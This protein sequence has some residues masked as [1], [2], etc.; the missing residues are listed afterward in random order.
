MKLAV[1]ADDLTGANDTGVQFAKKGF[2]TVVSL[3]LRDEGEERIASGY[4]EVFVFDTDSRSAGSREAYERVA[5]VSRLLKS[6]QVD[7]IYKKM[8][9][10]M[11]G[12]IGAE[13]DAVYD[14]FRPDFVAVA[15]AFPGNGR[16]V[17]DGYMYLHGKPLHETE[18]AKDPKTPVRES[19]IP[20]LLAQ[21][22]NRPIGH[23]GTRDLAMGFSHLQNR[24]S[25]FRRDGIS[26]VLFDAESDEDLALV[27]KLFAQTDYRVV[28]AGSAG[29]AAHLSDRNRSATQSGPELSA[30]RHPVLLVVGSLSGKSRL[31]LERVLEQADTIGFCLYPERVVGERERK[32]EELDRIFRE[33]ARLLENKRENGFIRRMV[34]YTSDRP[35]DREKAKETGILFG[36]DSRTVSNMVAAALGEISARLVRHYDL[37][38]LVLTGGDTARQVCAH[39]NVRELRLLE[40][41]EPG[42]PVGALVGEDG[43]DQGYAV[44][45]AGGF[46]S[47]T[48]L[49]KAADILEGAIR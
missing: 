15:P 48:A 16:T 2:H 45:K 27:V 1:I 34:L 6:R 42:I 18:A 36:R 14:V 47:E 33:A 40:E 25:A 29:L 32:R 5:K 19:Y 24:L 8:D 30:C 43:S 44:T 21:Q 4:G 31:Q 41:V 23:I 12:N 46:G 7:K 28:W 49:V 38:R 11:R 13:L 17:V 26:Y 10:T 22:T 39:L 20:R 37:N 35:E 3:E 9:S